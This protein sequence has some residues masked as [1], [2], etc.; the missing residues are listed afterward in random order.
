MEEK[1]YALS[2]YE[3]L[4]SLKETNLKKFYSKVPLFYS[5]TFLF[6]FVCFSDVLFYFFTFCTDSLQIGTFDFDDEVDLINEIKKIRVFLDKSKKGKQNEGDGGDEK[7]GSEEEVRE[8]KEQ[9]RKRDQEILEKKLADLDEEDL[10]R[11][12]ILKLQMAQKAARETQR[13]AKKEKEEE[14]ERRK[15]EEKR[16]EEEIEKL[17][18]LLVFFISWTLSPSPLSFISSYLSHTEIRR[19]RGVASKIEDAEVAFR[20]LFERS[21]E[22]TR[23]GRRSTRLADAKKNEVA[24]RSF[25]VNRSRHVL[26]MP[27]SLFVLNQIILQHLISH[28]SS[29]S[30]FSLQLRKRRQRLECLRR[31]G[32]RN[33]PKHHPT[34]GPAR[35]RACRASVFD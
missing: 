28:L 4:L 16:K 32:F 34:L 7:E 31:D 10:K 9:Q 13:M 19:S 35:E 22:E 12:K 33:R 11:K 23:E 17:V 8:E 3:N 27:I 18:C 26:D 24:S 20:V 2:V 30:L 15:E 21:K 6:F 14:E 29:L 5:Y 1:K 25:H